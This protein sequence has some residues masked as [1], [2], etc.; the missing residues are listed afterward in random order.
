MAKNSG[1]KCY[2]LPMFTVLMSLFPRP[3]LSIDHDAVIA[4]TQQLFH[5]DKGERKCK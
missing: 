3:S 2:H 1:I 4:P 5:T